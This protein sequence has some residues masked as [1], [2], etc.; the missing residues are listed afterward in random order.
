MVDIGET[1]T[2]LFI[3]VEARNEAEAVKFI[4]RS[5][6]KV[7]YI[8]NANLGRSGELAFVTRRGK[9]SEL[10]KSIDSLKGIGSIKDIISVIMV[11]ED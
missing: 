3:R 2:K 10:Y 11:I 1:E 8:K 5:F 7:E 4:D 6:G 9:R